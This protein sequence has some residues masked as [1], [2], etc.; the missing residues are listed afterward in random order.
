MPVL[1][2][3]ARPVRSSTSARA[4]AWPPWPA[5]SGRKE[6]CGGPCPR[7]SAES[8]EGVGEERDTAARRWAT[9]DPAEDCACR[10]PPGVRHMR[11]PGARDLRVARGRGRG[12]KIHRGRPHTTT[13][14]GR[15]P[16]LRHSTVRHETLLVGKPPAKRMHPSAQ[17]SPDQGWWRHSCRFRAEGGMRGGTG[18]KATC[19]HATVLISSTA[20]LDLERSCT[21]Q[22]AATD[23]CSLPHG[24]RPQRETLAP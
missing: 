1:G 17:C 8:L 6:R 22:G 3:A 2:A 16:L 7:R 18:S 14:P 11:N 9:L 13:I 20:C 21:A 19:C 15:G 5:A 4:C 12:R 24:L 23:R 10:R